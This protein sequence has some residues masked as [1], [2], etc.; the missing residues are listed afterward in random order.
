MTF[1]R[2]DILTGMGSLAA[3][4]C[5]PFEAAAAAARLPGKIGLQLFTVRE[6]FAA[7]PVGTLGKVAK[8]G[9]REVEFGGGG[10][11]A[12]DHRLLRATMDRLGL[13]CP[14]LHIAYESLRDRL[15]AS[16]AMAKTL[17]ADTVV[18]PYML[19]QYRSPD[20]WRAALADFGRIAARLR[21]AGLGFAYHNHDFEFAAQPGGTTLFDMLLKEM[22]PAL[23]K[24]ELDLYW[25]VF[26]GQDVP[27]LIRSLA[28]RIYA[29]HVKDMAP[30]RVMAAVGTGGIDFAAIF[31]L[32]EI[33]GVRHFFVENDRAPAPYIPDITRS[34]RTLRALRF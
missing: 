29:Y 8:V 3:L 27:A 2:R 24:I 30:D 10:Y 16:I 21:E 31:K 33:A 12:M 7:D 25:A 19:D 15:D 17:G 32:N 1:D 18:L 5:L 22:D 26:A 4:A 13:T 14:A 9:Y 6:I 20:A 28:G 34:F 11:D 23:L